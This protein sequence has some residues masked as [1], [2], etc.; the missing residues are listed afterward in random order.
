[1]PEITEH[2]P[3]ALRLFCQYPVW[4][5]PSCT[6]GSGNV[7][8][9]R[10]RKLRPGARS[11]VDIGDGRITSEDGQDSI[12]PVNIGT[13]MSNWKRKLTTA[14]HPATYRVLIVTKWNVKYDFRTLTR[15]WQPRINSYIV[16]C[17]EAFE[18]FIRCPILSIN[19]YI[20]K[21]KDWNK[22]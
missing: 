20:V 5:C 13:Q 2:K 14:I 16:E 9:P 1:M 12:V 6:E 3:L 19:S 4:Q 11:R 17:K 21:C 7:S 15:H 10:E 8:H 22:E 18:S